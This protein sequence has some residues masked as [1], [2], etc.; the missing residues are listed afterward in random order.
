MIGAGSTLFVDT[1][2]L[3]HANAK[4]SPLH[5]RAIR[6][7]EIYLELGVELWISRQVLREYMAIVTQANVFA[8]PLPQ[9]TAIARIRFFRDHFR[10]TEDSARITENLLK[11]MEKIP[12]NGGRLYDAYII[13]TMQTFGIDNLLTAEPADYAAYT[14]LIKVIPLISDTVTN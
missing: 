9:P 4:E 14:H 12:V 5:E 10:V 8:H 2:V 6:S 13:S 7:L 11:L 3:I 1:S